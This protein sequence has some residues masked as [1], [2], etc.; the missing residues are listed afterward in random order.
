[1]IF[2]GVAVLR[3]CAVGGKEGFSGHVVNLFFIDF[4]L[5]LLIVLFY[6]EWTGSVAA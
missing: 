3:C 1:M 4:V 5:L 6:R 2:G